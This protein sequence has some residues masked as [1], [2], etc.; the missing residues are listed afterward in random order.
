MLRSKGGDSVGRGISSGSIAHAGR[1]PSELTAHPGRRSGWRA[2]SAA[3]SRT[4]LTGTV[5]TTESLAYFS[6][7]FHTDN[8]RTGG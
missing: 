2:G 4:A 5:S 1:A 8:R 6:G 3:T 7:L